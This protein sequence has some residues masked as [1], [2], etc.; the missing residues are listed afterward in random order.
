LCRAFRTANSEMVLVWFPDNNSLGRRK[1][2]NE[3][4]LEQTVL[5]Q[6]SIK[7]RSLVVFELLYL[8]SECV[9]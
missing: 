6:I 3:H 1:S 2:K 7:D 5:A 8:V 4:D 9:L